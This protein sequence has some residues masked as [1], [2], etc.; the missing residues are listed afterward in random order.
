MGCHRRLHVDGGA[1]LDKLHT[2]LA[3]DDNCI[4]HSTGWWTYRLCLGRDIRQYHVDDGEFP[5]KPARVTIDCTCTSVCRHHMLVSENVCAHARASARSRAR[6]DHSASASA[7]A[8]AVIRW[9]S[10][11]LARVH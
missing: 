10:D 1:V 9:P 6:V 8:C 4:T 2:G 5:R 7:Q 11:I 3:G